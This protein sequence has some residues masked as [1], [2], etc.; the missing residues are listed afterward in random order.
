MLLVLGIVALAFNLRAAIT[1][2]PPVFPELAARLRL[3]PSEVTVL[4]A[5]PVVCFGLVSAP[6]AR[7]SR[8]FGE[9]RVLFAAL[10]ALTCGLLLRGAAPGPMLFP[11]TALASGASDTIGAHATFPRGGR[12]FAPRNP[13]AGLRPAG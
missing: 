9:E 1:S 10:A 4:A 6:A 12:R 5:I 13:E 11:G 2:L 3:S 7:L 8:R